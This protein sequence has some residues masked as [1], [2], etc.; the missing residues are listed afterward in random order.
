MIADAVLGFGFG[1]LQSAVGL[2]PEVQI[3]LPET[4]PAVFSE[5]VTLFGRMNR[6]VPIA[7]LLLIA[8]AG[9]VLRGGMF[10]LWVASFIYRRIPIIGG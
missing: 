6:Y 3:E 9:L 2:L 7:E 1:L 10:A 4:L 8:S 5:G